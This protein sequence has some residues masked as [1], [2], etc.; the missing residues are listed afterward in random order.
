MYVPRSTTNWSSPLIHNKTEVRSVDI[1][2]SA[3]RKLT[4]E[5]DDLIDT[6][7]EPEFLSYEKLSDIY[8]F[9]FQD[10]PLGTNAQEYFQ[11]KELLSSIEI[12]M[13]K[14]SI[15]GLDQNRLRIKD[16][17]CS[18]DH[19]HKMAELG[20][21]LFYLDKNPVL[22]DHPSLLSF[23]ASQMQ[24]EVER[25]L[26]MHQEVC[27]DPRIP[28]G[29]T[30]YLM[31]AFAHMVMTKAQVFNLGGV[32][33]IKVLLEDPTFPISL[34]LQP[35]HR[36]HILVIIKQIL[37][38]PQFGAL[39]E[40]KLGIHPSLEDIIRLDL[41]LP[42]DAPIHSS[43]ILWDLMMMFFSDV[44]QLN[45]PNCYAVS[46]LIYGME[47]HLCKVASRVLECLS[48][49]FLQIGLGNTI[50]IAPL[51]EKRLE[52]V[53]DL[54]LIPERGKGETLSPISHISSTLSVASDRAENENK[55]V[56][57]K[58]TLSSILHSEG[59]PEY[60]PY[61]ERLYFAYK[62]NTLVHMMLG[63]S[64]LTFMN[65]A[66]S[67]DTMQSSFSFK[68]S[69]IETV[70]S[71]LESSQSGYRNSIPV[72]FRTHL[73]W[74]LGQRLWLE[75]CNEQKVS[76]NNRTLMIGER[77]IAGFKG[78]LN[79]LEALFKQSLRI[80]SLKGK[81]Y[82]MIH[83][84]SELQQVVAKEIEDSATELA[85]NHSNMQNLERRLVLAARSKQFR[86]GISDFCSYKIKMQGILGKHLNWADL[87][88]LRQI[89]G[90]EYVVLQTVF[91]INVESEQISQCHT[92]YQFLERLLE[93]LK[94]FD[95]QS[96]KS[97]PK[98]LI[99]TPGGHAWTLSTEC[100]DI[101]LKNSECFYEFIQAEVFK[102][103]KTRMASP[104]PKA[105]IERVVDRYTEKQWLREEIKRHFEE[106]GF[107][108]FSKFRTV[109]CDKIHIDSIESLENIMEEEFAKISVTRPELRK[110][111][112]SLNIKVCDH[113][114]H[115]LY[116]RL[117]TICVSPS[118]LAKEIRL[119]LLTESL[120]V[121]E[122]QEIE[123]AICYVAKL[124]ITLKLG[125][126]NWVDIYREDPFHLELEIGFSYI[127]NTLQYRVRNPNSFERKDNSHFKVFTLHHPK[128][129]RQQPSKW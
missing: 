4:F 67:C 128:L 40:K 88:V 48:Q 34:Y 110:I 83:T 5:E 51:V 100:W 50:P 11:V 54:D 96:F 69:L 57:I 42:P 28:S 112:S 30:H 118:Q 22:P 85:S 58:L 70:L 35:E 99:S 113:V 2:T 60:L 63:V 114:F 39:F 75:N 31:R 121:V 97:V 64:E 106:A 12:K 27:D 21:V 79:G 15:E 3:K 72:Y 62:Y 87:L 120:A 23:R 73:K 44:R 122:L 41:K 90:L 55:S 71:S 111:L 126:L 89:G 103:G 32:I 78:N 47:N 17:L 37:T 36:S 38:H 43:Y 80:F 102:P 1:E 124:P 29:K 52:Y 25:C 8:G 33:A 82:R 10:L 93:R 101:L 86:I 24:L 98:L 18:K 59:K 46:A 61:A 104:V 91:G 84:L 95:P 45:A 49:G 125:D 9:N 26:K 20:L 14:G 53:H 68:E 19:Q 92:P 77:Q 115:R 129:V 13:T 108:S 105:T 6:K 123:Y 81:E 107:V 74:R 117:T 16:L 65:K 76:H 94:T 116:D 109:F 66:Q 127:Q 56:K 7:E 119:N